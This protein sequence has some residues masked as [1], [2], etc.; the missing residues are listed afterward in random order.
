MKNYW[1]I[2]FLLFC[3]QACK[4]EKTIRT[5]SPAFYHW[6]T[7]LKINQTEKDYIDSLQVKTIYAKFFDVD[8]DY[9]RQAP[10]PQAQI[11]LNN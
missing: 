8:W 7:N 1:P 3:L 9:K 2:F 4:Q 6:Q 10:E 5:I 11:I